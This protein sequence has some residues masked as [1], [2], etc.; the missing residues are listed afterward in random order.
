MSDHSELRR[1]AEVCTRPVPASPYE[2]VTA[3]WTRFQQAA[4][5]SRILALLDEVERLRAGLVRIEHE[6]TIR[7]EKNAA[8][9]VADFRHLARHALK[10]PTP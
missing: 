8:Q 2:H 7:R 9:T 1:L 5:P 6:A 10:G 3:P 4:N